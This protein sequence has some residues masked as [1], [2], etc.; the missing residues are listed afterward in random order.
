MPRGA[1]IDAARWVGG[2]ALGDQEHW[3]GGCTRGGLSCD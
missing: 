1:E 2:G 3:T